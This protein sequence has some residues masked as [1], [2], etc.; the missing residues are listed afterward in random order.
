MNRSG[1]VTRNWNDVD[2]LVGDT[3]YP[4]SRRVMAFHSDQGAA[5]Y[6]TYGMAAPTVSATT[7]SNADG[8]DGP[9]IAHITSAVSGN[10]AYVRTSYTITRRD[11]SPTFAGRFRLSGTITTNTYWIGLFSADP[12]ALTSLATIHGAAFGYSTVTDGTAFWRTV[13]SDGANETRTTTTRAVAGATGYD[14]RIDLGASAVTFYV[15]G[16]VI[17]SHTATLP[18]STQTLGALAGVTTHAIANRRIVVG[19]MALLHI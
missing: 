12:T 9:W 3:L 11:W 2:R 6:S 16:V 1:P 8:T 15:D 17:S 14:L 5:T 19:R 18:T 10:A 13:T 4:W 7:T